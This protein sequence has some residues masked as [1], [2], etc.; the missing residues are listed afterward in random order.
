MYYHIR[1]KTF[2]FCH[3][4]IM[5]ERIPVMQKRK[6]VFNFKSIK[7]RGSSV[8]T[9]IVA[10]FT[11]FATMAY[12]L[13][14][15]TGMMI[16]A[17]MDGAGVMLAT[18]LISGVISIAMGLYSNMPFSLA[19]GMGTNAVLAY[20]LVAGGICDWQTGMGVVMIGGIIFLV[21][22]LFNI[23]E[24]VV[25]IIPKVLKVGI[26]AGIGIFLVR[27]SLVNAALV[28]PDFGGLGDFSDPN[29][30]LAAI[31]LA[32]TLFLYFFRIEIKGRVYCIRGSLLISIALIT[33]IGICMGLVTLPENI[34]TTNAVSSLS[35]VVWKF[36]IVK[37]FNPT[38]IP[39]V[40]IFFMGDFFSTLGTALGVAG[41][42]NMLDENGNLPAIGKVFLVDA[43]GTCLGAA[44][45]LTTV[46]TYVESAAGVDAGGRTG[47]T[48][49][50]TGALF[51]LSMLFA[52]LFLMIPTAATSPVLVC[53]GISMMQ[54]LG[55][56]DFADAEWYPV[57]IM[58]IVSLFAGTA[59]AIALGLVAY[60]LIHVVRYAFTKERSRE[61]LPSIATVILTILSC[62]QFVL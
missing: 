39:F 36:D 15:H 2:H 21:L 50:T 8:G 22:S 52:P 60:C 38:L 25:E 7:E 33:I 45:G 26:G 24:K 51:L 54:T 31:G 49:I 41:K 62:L 14:V 27:L 5:K 28:A 4:Q 42:A 59:N 11:A 32:I 3:Y 43:V 53:I 13:A 12:V 16:D 6:D 40:I 56:V 35:K 55:N 58:V 34:F 9:E 57:A 61:N 19:P 46:T 48:S 30:M 1:V 37:A 23:R 10:G 17:G 47:L 44:F 18:A 29:V 20:T